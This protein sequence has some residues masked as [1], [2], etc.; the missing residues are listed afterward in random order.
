MEDNKMVPVLEKVKAGAL[1]F[2]GGG[3]FSQATFYFK[4]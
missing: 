3:F 1:A 2:I 4:E